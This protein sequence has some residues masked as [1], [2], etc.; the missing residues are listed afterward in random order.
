MTQSGVT[1]PAREAVRHEMLSSARAWGFVKRIAL[2]ILVFPWFFAHCVSRRAVGTPAQGCGWKEMK[3]IRHR[4][5]PVLLDARRFRP[6][7]IGYARVNRRS[8]QPKHL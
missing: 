3:R 6:S 4:K 7:L 1:G 5:M 2:G 8:F